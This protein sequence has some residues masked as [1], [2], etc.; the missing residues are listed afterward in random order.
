MSLI[1]TYKDAFKAELNDVVDGLDE[2]SILTAID[3][4]SNACEKGGR[5][6]F[7]GIGKP[8][9]VAKYMSS[10]FSSTGTPSYFLDGTEAVHGSLGQ[11][12]SKDVVV[13]I[14]NSGETQELLKTLE[15]LRLLGI[16][17]IG[18][19]SNPES[20]LAKYST[21]HLTA[22]VDKEGD[23]LNKPPRLSILK[24]MVVLQLVSIG[25]QERLSLTK[26][27]YVKWHPAGTIGKDVSSEIENK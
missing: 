20:T 22:K 5:L 25:C 11:V 26:E 7:T 10:L 15:G 16:T 13:A 6:H 9:Y 14:S 3:L 24:E 12:C 21:V 8:S 27:T 23:D 18:V 4:I 19:S 17:I 1:K 2:A